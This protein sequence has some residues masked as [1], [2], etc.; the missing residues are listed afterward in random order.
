M[1][2]LI[3]LLLLITSVAAFGQSRPFSEG[4]KIPNS[5]AV[6]QALGYTPV[7]KAGDTMTGAL[8]PSSTAGIVGTTLADNANAGSFGEELTYALTGTSL[9]SPSTSNCASGNLTAG[10]WLVQGTTTFIPAG[11][12]VPTL[13][14]TGISTTSVTFATANTGASTS[15]SLSF[16]A[17]QAQ[18]FSTPIYRVNVNTNTTVYLVASSVFTVSTMTCNGFIRAWRPR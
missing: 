12:T 16:T 15:W 10:D 18:V 3:S 4:P 7:N 17:G 9:T 5:Q 13:M 11:S 1:R 14:Q 6:T 2:K 8:T